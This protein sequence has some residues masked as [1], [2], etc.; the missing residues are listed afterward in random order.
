MGWRK[1][2]IVAAPRPM[3][4]VTPGQERQRDE[5]LDERP[6]RALHA[7]GVEDQVVA[8]PDGVEAERS[9]SWTPSIEQVLV[10]LLAEVGEEEPE[11]RGH[12]VVFSLP[13]ALG[14]RLGWA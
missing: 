5:R 2:M 12:V 9:A 6:V 10:G 1:G 4:S 11:T 7:V 8:H 3:R 13:V 14:Q